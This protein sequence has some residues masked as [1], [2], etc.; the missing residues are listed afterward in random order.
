[1]HPCT[2]ILRFVQYIQFVNEY[3]C[4]VWSV[5]LLDDE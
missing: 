1:M 5:L 3:L 2:K 4:I